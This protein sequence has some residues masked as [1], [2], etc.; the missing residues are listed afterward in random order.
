MS[1][2]L[3]IALWV[4]QVCLCAL[5]L[6]AGFTKLTKTPQGM[7]EMGWAWAESMPLRLIRFIG[8]MEVLGAIGIVLP[9]LTHI[10]PALVPAAAVG[11][12]LLQVSAIILHT[13]RGEAANLWFNLILLAASIF[14]TWGR[15]SR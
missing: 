1:S 13:R 12:V 9:A 15:W 4:A 3:S 14:V 11:F 6:F 10:M 8:V 7:A 2:W 5:F